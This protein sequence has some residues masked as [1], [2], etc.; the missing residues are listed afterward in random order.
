MPEPVRATTRPLATADE[1]LAA[2]RLYREVF[3]LTE[4]DPTITPK[5]LCA[6]QRHGGS[7]VGAFDDAG[8]LVGFTYGFVGLDGAVAYHHSQAA[9][10]DPRLQ[11]RGVGRELKRAQGQVALATGVEFMRWAYDPMQARNAHFNLDVLGARGRWFHRDY[12]GMSEDL[13]PSDRI[14]VD[15]ALPQ[16]VQNHDSEPALPSPAPAWGET[17]GDGDQVWLAIPA[18]WSRL[19]HWN[20]PRAASLRDRVAGQLERLLVDGRALVSCRRVGEDTAVYRIAE[21]LR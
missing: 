7:A 2:V 16:P 8:L 15:W 11:G 21:E 18:H 14:V 17:A 10:V 20:P 1:R 3:G 5:L 6:L 9:V 19:V 4:T 13:G 12:Y